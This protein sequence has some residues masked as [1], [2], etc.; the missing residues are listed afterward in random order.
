[1]VYGGAAH[2]CTHIGPQHKTFTWDGDAPLFEI[3]L[4]VSGRA[5]TINRVREIHIHQWASK[6]EGEEWGYGFEKA[7]SVWK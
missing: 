7:N 3:L 2:T 4:V 1:M 5:L 6:Q